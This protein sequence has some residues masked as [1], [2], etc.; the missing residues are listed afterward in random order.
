MSNFNP[1]KIEHSMKG[2]TF[3]ATKG[4]IME[5]ARSNNAGEQE[6]EILKKLPD[7]EYASQE[8]IMGALKNGGSSKEE[9][10]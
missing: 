9:K 10:H 3:P 1:S 4:S 7:Q 6:M 5:S 2:I 8:D